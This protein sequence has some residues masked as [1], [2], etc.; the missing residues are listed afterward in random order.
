MTEATI[1]HHTTNS[2]TAAASRTASRGRVPVAERRRGVNVAVWVLQALLAG[3]YVFAALPKLAASEQAVTGFNQM[4]L[5]TTGM[6]LIGALELAGAIALLIPRL[7]GLASTCFVALMTG[8]VI[9]TVLT[10]GPS[11]AAFPAV[12]LI[13]V[14]VVAWTRRE[15]TTDLVR[16]VRGWVR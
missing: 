3:L 4:G 15:R 2:T 13:L 9:A 14:A 7:C 16:L 10:H 5:G 1:S 12:V 6:Y 11:L 8:A